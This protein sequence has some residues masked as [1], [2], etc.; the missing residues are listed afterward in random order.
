MG[1]LYKIRFFENWFVKKFGQD[2]FVSKIILLLIIKQW[3][4]DE[5]EVMQ[6]R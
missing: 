1:L 5:I 6:K 3:S 2:V 4:S